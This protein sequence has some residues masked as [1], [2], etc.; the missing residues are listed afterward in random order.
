MSVEIIED[1]E[2]TEV[3]K[4]E[5]N[6]LPPV[7]LAVRRSGRSVFNTICMGFYLLA[8]LALFVYDFVA[9]TFV[10]ATGI[11]LLISWLVNF[12][13]SN[14]I[15]SG[16]GLS[17]Q[18]WAYLISALLL[19]LVSQL[20]EFQFTN[21]LLVRFW[22][23]LGGLETFVPKQYGEFVNEVFDGS[24]TVAV[25]L[26]LGCLCTALSFGS[27]TRSKR[28][29][30]PFTKTL[31]LSSVVNSLLG[32]FLVVM[33]LMELNLVIPCRCPVGQKTALPNA[34]LYF[35]FGAVLLLF[36]V[37]LLIIYIKMRKVRNAVF[38]A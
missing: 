19:A 38:K 6:F 3:V 23:L 16:F 34:I 2:E 20:D 26:G 13:K 15:A 1:I 18:R 35:A 37:R 32:V 33:G 11:L 25:C 24:D 31:F 28:K 14:N 27:L 17:L 36:A 12:K 30:L 22:N 7:V 8:G 9:G 5:N 10:L 29:N 4:P 21:N